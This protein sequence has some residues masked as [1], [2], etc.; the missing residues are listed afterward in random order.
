M[1]SD[2]TELTE[3]RAAPSRARIFISY[4]RTDEAFA[5]SLS[6]ELEAR[7]IEVLR[8]VDETLPGEEWWRRL[9]SLIGAADAIVF[10]LSRRSA[11]SKVCREEVAHGE[12]LKKR[13]FPA[14]I[15]DVDWA[16]VPSGLAARHSVFFKSE[17]KRAASVD[18]LV[19]ALLTDIDWIRE[20]TRLFERAATWQRQGRGRHELLSGRALDAAE[21]WLQAQPVAAESPTA[22]HRE[23]IKAGRDA[24]TRRRKY[25][26]GSLAAGIVVLAGVA[27]AALWQRGVAVHNFEIAT[28]AAESMVFDIAQSLRNMQGLS[29]EAV[30]KI[31]ET[32][33]TAFDQLAEAAPDDLDLQRSRAAMLGQFGRTYLTL[34][35]LEAAL[36]AYREA[37]TISGRLVSSDPSNTRWQHDLSV[38]Y[39]SVGEVLAAQGK[40]EEALKAHRD[41]LAIAE[42]L[43][44]FD[45]TQWQRALPLSYDAVGDVLALQGKLEEALTAFRESLAIR[46]RFAAANPSNN[47]WQGDLTV[48]YLKVGDVLRMQRKLDEALKAYR[49]GL[50]IAERLAA[51][52][53]S[54]TQWQRELLLSYQRVGEVLSLLGKLEEALEAWRDSLAIA[55]PLAASDRS[56]ARWERDLHVSHINIGGVLLMQGKVEEALKAFRNT[57]TLAER[58]AA[59]N[60]SDIQRQYELAAVYDNLASIYEK[61]ADVAQALTELRKVRH[62]MAALVAGAPDNAE[63]KHDLGRCEREIARLEGL[64]RDGARN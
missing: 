59:A 50:V 26:M 15:E 43:I 3:C 14:V 10:V 29:A 53:R 20:H 37:L 45:R 8:D 52:E 35:D 61:L 23:Y 1:M 12:A 4:S 17:A 11:E 31:L 27:G 6:Q 58:R 16:S 24:A 30:R 60:P 39:G 7:G 46:E 41:S 9:Q 18:Q 48:S 5:I 19:E 63:W 49:D 40:L 47:E 55:E 56:N 33:K 54:N 51:S 28:R 57:L 36:K 21:Q 25:F 64:A 13:I 34:G 22:L 32:A 44:T 38:F 2:S 42:H 62:I